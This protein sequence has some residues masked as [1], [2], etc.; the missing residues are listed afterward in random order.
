MLEHTLQTRYEERGVRLAPFAAADLACD[1]IFDSI[2][3]L[4]NIAK[5]DNS[6]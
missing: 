5:A 6:S 3:S 2:L 1:P 4:A